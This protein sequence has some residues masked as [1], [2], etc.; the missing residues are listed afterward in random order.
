[1]TAT[2]DNS[3]DKVIAINRA[4]GHDQDIDQACLLLREYC[5]DLGG[6]RPAELVHIW[7]NQLEAEPSWI[8]SAIVE[9]LYQGRYK[10]LSVEQILRGWKRRGHPLRHFNHEFERVVF[11]PVDS[12]A[13]KY[14]PM[15][16]LRP[17]ELLTPQPNLAQGTPVAMPTSESGPLLEAPPVPVGERLPL[18]NQDGSDK[19]RATPPETSSPTVPAPVTAAVSPMV[20]VSTEADLPRPKLAALPGTPPGAGT[21]PFTQPPPIRKFT[22]HPEPSEFYYRLQ[23]VA[24]SR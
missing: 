12:T 18:A 15:T 9:A 23:S 16:T 7:Q 21:T 5:F 14:A 8:R 24:R 6:Y 19:Q 1:M 2:N 17:S 20:E 11:G 22:P 3:L 13:R 4:A 10:A